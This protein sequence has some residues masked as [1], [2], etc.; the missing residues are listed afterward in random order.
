MGYPTSVYSAATKNS[1]DTV[2]AAHVNVLDAEVTAIEQGLI[3]GPISLPNSTVANLSVTGGSTFT[4]AVVFNGAVTITAPPD[5]CRLELATATEVP[6]GSTIVIAWDRPVFKT[7]SSMHSSAVNADRVTPQSSG[8]YAFVCEGRF[9][10]EAGRDV[11]L[12]VEDSSGG[13]LASVVVESSGA[14]SVVAAGLK[15]FDSVSGSTQWVRV[16][17][18][19]GTSTNSLSTVAGLTHFDVWKLR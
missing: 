6:S 9:R 1:G 10:T 19:N 13:L 2:Q 11:Q 15:Y 8:V 5:A 14:Q 7:N 4:G 12:Q 17:A 16:V 18:F 3:T